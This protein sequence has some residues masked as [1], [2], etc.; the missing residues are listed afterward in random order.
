MGHVAPIN[1][2]FSDEEFSARQDRVRKE[3]A[4]Q[5]LDGLLLFKIEDMYWL[6]G[7]DTDGFCIFHA[8][9]LSTG[10][11]THVSRTA[12]LANVRYSSTCEDVRVWI[13][14]SGESKAAAIRDT[15]AAH[16]LA[17]GRVGIQLDTM[18]LT[19][20]LYEELRAELDGWCTLTDASDLVR[21]LRLV[22]SPAELAYVRRA[23]EIVDACRDVAI[24]GTRPGTYEGDLMGRI[25]ATVF[26][27][28]GD[29]PAHRS[30]IGHG[31]SALNTRYTTAHGTIG[32]ND[33]VTYELGAGYRHYHAA[34]M[35]TVLTGPRVDPRYRRMHAA[36]HEALHD[37]RAR[38]RPGRTVGE[39]YEAHRAALARH[40]YAHAALAACGYTMGATWPPTWMEQPQ[41]Y[42]GNPVV[43]AAGMTFFT[44]MVLVDAETGL[45]MSLGEQAIITEGEP[46]PV[47]T[48]PHEPIV[49][50]P[51]D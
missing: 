38:L 35:F 2:H 22:K 44:H 10:G 39:L 30:P 5:G 37:V 8:M 18:G 40:G 33:Q 6:T 41:I 14:G 24:A 42:A 9:V 43:L 17:G 50:A 51:P 36:C 12:D 27:A 25:W 4:G 7:L 11:L 1:Q 49:A 26:E 21:T 48:V 32:A 23:G 3:L 34:G 46:E 16:G 20:R 31:A 47:T 15:L 45:T 19:P 28:D 13:D 29:P